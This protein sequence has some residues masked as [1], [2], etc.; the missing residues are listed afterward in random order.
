MWKQSIVS[1]SDLSFFVF[2]VEKNKRKREEDYKIADVMSKEVTV[3]F[4]NVDE[5][6]FHAIQPFLLHMSSFFCFLFQEIMSKAKKPKVE[7]EVKAFCLYTA[8]SIFKNWL[9]LLDSRT[10]ESVDES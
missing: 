8:R 4:W 7:D 10:W 6:R 2:S 3:S 1:I 9:L 5:C